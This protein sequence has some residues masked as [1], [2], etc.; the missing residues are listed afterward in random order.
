MAAAEWRVLSALAL[1]ESDEALTGL[2]DNGL[3]WSSLLSAAVGHRML[4][5]LAVLVQ[6]EAVFVPRGFNAV[7]DAVL[8]ANRHRAR[9]V[10]K[11][12]ARL[13]S[14]LD[15]AAVPAVVTKGAALFDLLYDGDGTRWFADLDLMIMPDHIDAAASALAEFGYVIG[16]TG[17]SETIAPLPRGEALAYVLS[18]DHVM[19]HARKTGDSI[20]PVL[21]VDIAYSLT[22]ASADWE[23]PVNEA[24]ATR[25]MAVVGDELLP[26]FAAAFHFLFVVLHVFREGWFERTRRP[27][28]AQV[29]DVVRF[30]KRMRPA[31]ISEVRELIRRYQLEKPVSW[32]CGNIDEAFGTHL[33]DQFGTVTSAEWLQECRG[34]GNR[35]LRWRAPLRV[36]MRDSIWATSPIGGEE[37]DL[38]FR[39]PPS[40][41]HP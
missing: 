12:A 21:E 22:W 20:I 5:S 34:A 2:S 11:E 39:L 25:T 24:M 38:S 35:R 40:L 27:D 28:L 26:V 9:R 36:R 31:E 18:P 4:P 17:L 37:L 1:D 7:L 3:S 16:K 32:V 10:V 6:S 13:T 33:S 19:R 15:N 30:A 29:R 23:V 8:L 14:Q 41:R